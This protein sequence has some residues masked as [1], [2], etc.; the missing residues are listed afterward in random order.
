LPG[1]GAY[2]GTI[3]AALFGIERKKA[4]LAIAI[5]VFISCALM[6]AL[7]YAGRYGVSLLG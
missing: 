2:T 5:G 7:S 1:T 4:F 6:V 3:A